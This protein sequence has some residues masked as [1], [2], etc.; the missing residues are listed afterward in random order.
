MAINV[1]GWDAQKKRV[2]IHFISKQ[3]TVVKRINLL[4]IERNDNKH[5]TWI[6]DFNRLLFDQ[7]KHKTR[8]Y[9]CEI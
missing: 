4:L 3:P 5:Y 7:P 8:K 6:K 1:F 2:I 9:F